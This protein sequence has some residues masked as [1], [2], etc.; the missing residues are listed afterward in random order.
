MVWKTESDYW[1]GATSNQEDV[2]ALLY[3][4]LKNVN[5]LVCKNCDQVYLV[6]VI[7]KEKVSI[8]C[9]QPISTL[10]LIGEEK[11]E[12]DW[13]KPECKREETTIF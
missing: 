13:Y 10:K 4:M 5:L 2:G 7:V 9:Y 11:V 6:I 3:N 8:C 1:R 12:K